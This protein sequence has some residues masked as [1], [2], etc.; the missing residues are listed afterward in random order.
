MVNGGVGV[1]DGYGACFVVVVFQCGKLGFGWFVVGFVSVVYQAVFAAV[2][3]RF[4]IRGAHYYVYVFPPIAF[5]KQFSYYSC[6][7]LWAVA[8]FEAI[9]T[10]I[11]L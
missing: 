5:H 9:R 6:D 4:D 1:V 7:I 2:E 10:W 3:G 8:F 11:V